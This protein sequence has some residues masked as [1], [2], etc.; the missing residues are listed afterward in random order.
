M[1]DDDTT[2]DTWLEEAPASPPETLSTKLKRAF[3][4][5]NHALVVIIIEEMIAHAIDEHEAVNHSA[6]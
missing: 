4:D 2:E 6:D 3:I 1:T 5:H